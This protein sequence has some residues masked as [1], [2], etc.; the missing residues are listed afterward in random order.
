MKT[1]LMLLDRFRVS[2]L[3]VGLIALTPIAAHATWPPPK[4]EGEELAVWRAMAGLV[5]RDNASKPYKLWYSQSDFAAA[6]FIA[7]ALADPDKE[8]FCGLSGTEVQSMISQLKSVSLDPIELEPD[9]AESVG[10]KIAHKKNPRFRYFA[11]S[12]VVFDSSQQ[13]AWLSVELNGE[14]G[15]IVRMD[16]IAGEWS[17]TSRCGGWYMPQE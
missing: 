9:V 12:R 8:Q 10:F 2:G 16:K 13:K 4:A 3:L 5:A 17:R 7:S 15:S 6:S 1:L 14:R 11:L